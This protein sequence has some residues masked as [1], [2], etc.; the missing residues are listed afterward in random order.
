MRRTVIGVMGAGDAASATEVAHARELGERIASEGWVLLTGGRDAGVMAAAN[1]GAKRVHGSLTIGILPFHDSG[2]SL[3]VDV[4]IATDLGN[5]RNNVNVLSSDVVIACGVSGP[6]TVS[7][8]ALALK[9]HRPVV[10]LDADAAAAEFFSRMARRPILRAK[11]PEEAV[12][13]AKKL[14]G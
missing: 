10:L 7:E 9:N 1:E 14:L 13:M 11:S 2:A 5:G 3:D 12:A 8:I 4:V 6:G